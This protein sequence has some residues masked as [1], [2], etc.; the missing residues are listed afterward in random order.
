MRKI[1]NRRCLVTAATLLFLCAVGFGAFFGCNSA[2]VGQTLG[3][4]ESVIRAR[5]VTDNMQTIMAMLRNHGKI[6]FRVEIIP[7]GAR[8]I[9]T[10]ADPAIAKMLQIHAADMRLRMQ[11]D[12][13]IRPNDPLFQELL[14]HHSEVRMK[15]TDVQ[16]GVIEDETSANPQV[17]LLIRAHTKTVAEFVEY[18]LPRAQQPSPLPKGYRP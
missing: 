3:P 8:T 10:S 9:N 15:I 11:Q 5:T 16:D 12:V 6:R 14:K 2:V 18:G 4:S 1:G 17:T 13:S 7:G